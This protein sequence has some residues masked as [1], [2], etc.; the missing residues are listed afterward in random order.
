V[1]SA[2]VCERQNYQAMTDAKNDPVAGLLAALIALV[3]VAMVILAGFVCLHAVITDGWK[4]DLTDAAPVMLVLF[5]TGFGLTRSLQYRQ[6][7]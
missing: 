6:K 1:K 5:F 3:I 4:E 7:Q 2:W